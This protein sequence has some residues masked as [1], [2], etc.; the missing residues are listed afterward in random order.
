L[1]APWPVGCSCIFHAAQ[2]KRRPLLLAL[3]GK[4]VGAA[5]L[6][7]AILGL[8]NPCVIQLRHAPAGF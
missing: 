5:G 6:E 3:G 8:G 4:L 7:P 2:T 1:A